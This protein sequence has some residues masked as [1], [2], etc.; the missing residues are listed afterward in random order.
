MK[1]ET[2]VYL[3]SEN[4]K[5]IVGSDDHNDMIKIYDFQ[6]YP[7]A[8]GA[9]INGVITDEFE[10]KTTLK[11][12]AEAG[13]NNVSLVIDSG[14]ILSKSS[15]M[16]K[17]K[18]SQIIQFVKDEL[19][20][21]GE[22]SEDLIYDYAYL[23]PSEEGKGASQILCCALERKLISNYLDI[24]KECG[25]E[26]NAID[27]SINILSKLTQELTG[28]DDK[29]YMISILDGN[30]MTS[31]L[32]EK[33]HYKLSYRSRII[34]ARSD[35]AYGDEIASNIAHIYQFSKSGENSVPIE[36]VLFCGLLDE[37]AIVKERIRETIK[38]EAEDFPTSRSIYIVNEG[39]K[40]A[41]ELDDYILPVG[42][43]FRK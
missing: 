12:V 11:K 10:V 22:N 8:E 25:I 27:F 2:V 35:A 4:I 18:S 21:L 33:N 28:F 41:F 20:S 7:F 9:M 39:N 43:L 37:E 16:P 36:K 30:N 23:G 17:M 1:K 32:F 15:I 3:S 26:I 19:S 42:F 34:A 6:K 40:E 24:F 29:T 38:I 31:V 5:L 14:Q 13:Y